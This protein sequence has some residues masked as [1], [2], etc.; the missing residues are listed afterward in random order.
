[1]KLVTYGYQGETYVGVLSGENVIPV[2]AAGLPYQTMNDLVRMMTPEEKK[3]LERVAREG[4]SQAVP[5]ADTVKMSPIPRP[6]QDVVCLGIN[7][8]AH[9][10]EAARFH[11]EAFGLERPVAIYFAKRVN[12]A[13]PDGGEIDSHPGL[14]EKLDYESELGVILGKDCRKVAKE[15]VWD[16]IFGYTVINDVSARTVQTLHKQ[17]Y[18]GKSLDTFTPMGPCIV[19]ADEFEN[20]PRLAIRSYVNGELR[21]NSN[22]G[23]LINDIPHVIWELSQG[24]TLEAGTIIATGTPAGVGMGMTPPCFLKPGDVVTCEIEGIGSITNR[25]R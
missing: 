14:V 20:P 23:L 4:S 22:T 11:G 18:F 8:A 24:M 3:A 5:F 12:E 16:H 13:V 6:L 9:A 7:Y 2:S 10:E 25:I 1:M 15:D 21:Q 19:T 17:W